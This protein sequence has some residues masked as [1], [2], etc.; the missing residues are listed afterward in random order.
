MKSIHIPASVLLDSL[1]LIVNRNM[2]SVSFTVLVTM[3]PV[4]I[5]LTATNVNVLLESQEPTAL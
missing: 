3:A 2:M 5:K 1:A 4:R